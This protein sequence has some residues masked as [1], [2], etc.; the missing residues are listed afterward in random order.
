MDF[1]TYFEKTYF[2]RSTYENKPSRWNQ[3]NNIESSQKKEFRSQPLI[4]RIPERTLHSQNFGANSSFPFSWTFYFSPR[5]GVESSLWG[6]S[7]L[8]NF[9]FNLSFPVVGTSFQRP[10]ST[11]P[12]RSVCFHQPTD[13]RFFHVCRNPLRMGRRSKKLVL[14]GKKTSC[15]NQNRWSQRTFEI[16][17]KGIE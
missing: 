4:P 12:N 10:M 7:S 8:S 5:Y 3:K 9:R 16:H 14:C 1:L 11:K 17:H 2:K 13:F 15:A 6:L